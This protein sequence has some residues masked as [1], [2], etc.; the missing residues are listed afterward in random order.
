VF[1]SATEDQAYA[2]LAAAHQVVQ[3]VLVTSDPRSD[4]GNGLVVAA[5]RLLFAPPVD[6]TPA[7]LPR[8]EPQELA[9]TVGGDAQLAE[10]AAALIACAS[11][12]DG[13]IDPAR[14]R[15][16]V[17]YAHAMHVRDGWVRELLQ[18]ARG[19]LAWA[20]A[21]MTRRNISTFPGW[22]NPDDTLKPMQPYEAQTDDD[23]R[24]AERFLALEQLPKNSYGHQ[25]WAHF[26]KHGF[27]FP[28]EKHAFTGSFAVPHDGLHVLT[29]Y[30]TS[31]QGELL[32]STFT[33][34]MH[35]RDGLRAHILP[36]IF[37]WHIGHEV[38]GIGEQQGALD[39][40]KFLIA[41]QRGEA[42]ATD[43]LSV[44]WDFFAAAERDLE[45]L[46]WTYGIPPLLPA[47]AAE[48]GESRS[49]GTPTPTRTEQRPALVCAA[50]VLGLR[51]KR[52]QLVVDL[53]HLRRQDG[54]DLLAG[55]LAH[56]SGDVVQHVESRRVHPRHHVG[57]GEPAKLIFVERHH[58]SQP[59]DGVGRI[60]HRVAVCVLCVV[61]GVRR[62]DMTDDGGAE[63]RLTRPHRLQRD[64]FI[65][66]HRRRLDVSETVGAA[67]DVERGAVDLAG[68]SFEGDAAR[69]DRLDVAHPHHIVDAP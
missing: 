42:T 40:T 68:P 13:Q 46:R 67:V 6:V 15:R 8:I 61:I 52:F 14:L 19:H 9:R 36:V 62:F 23:K 31:I 29:G 25:F 28:G 5:G 49:P 57:V 39:P 66:E 34:A 7:D 16:V 18:V 35:R 11:L 45:E 69:F 53:G 43:V 54:D 12:A 59:V 2:I 58:H 17:E 21:D 32:V 64:A 37:E 3:Q 10:H 56:P 48:G 63:R 20:M 41:W 50:A 38:N 55:L 65:G 24:L 51:Q 33:G 30:S 44:D 22:A 27:A 47:D 4:R 60:G 26:R 1:E